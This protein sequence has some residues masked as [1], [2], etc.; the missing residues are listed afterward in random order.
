MACHIA[1]HSFR[2]ALYRRTWFL[3][4]A[5]CAVFPAAATA[6]EPVSRR[7]VEVLRQPLPPEDLSLET[8]DDV[9]RIVGPT[10]VYTVDRATGAIRSFSARRGDAVVVESTAPVELSLDGRKL[11]AAGVAEINVMHRTPAKIELRAAGV[12]MDPEGKSPP[13]DFLLE[14]TFY[15]D[16][17]VKTR[18]TLV[19]RAETAVT[20]DLVCRVPLE[21]R[22]THAFNKLR[23]DDGM[24]VRAAA[25]PGAG[26]SMS[27]TGAT[28]CLQ[29]FSSEAAVA[30]FTDRGGLN[31]SSPE[32]ETASIA[33]REAADGAVSAVLSQHIVRI[34]DGADPMTL[35]ADRVFVFRTGLAVAPNRL[36]HPRR[37]DVRIFFWAGDAKHPYPTD[38]EIYDVAGLGFNVFQMHRVGSPGLPREPEGELDR[39]IKTVHEANMLFQW[40]ENVDLMYAHDPAVLKMVADGKWNLWQ[41]FNY[42]GRYTASMDPYCDMKATC[43]ASPNGLAEYRV[44]TY[45]RMFARYP[46]D[47]MYVDDN[48]PYANCG[49]W[50]EHGHPQPV[51][52][53]L[54]EL[55]EVNW[56]RRRVFLEHCPHALL[57]D[58]CS[59]CTLLPTIGAFDSHLYGEGYN[60]STP[61]AYWDHFGALKSLYG[62]GHICPGD[63]ESVRCPTESAYAFDLLCGGGQYTYLDWRLYPQKFPHAA[64]VTPDERPLVEAYNLAQY[65]FGMYESTPFYF[66]TSKNHFTTTAPS[67][68]AT[69]YRNDTWGDWLLALA[70]MAQEDRTTTLTLHDAAAIGL[71]VGAEWLLWDVGQRT[72]RRLA[73]GQL[74]SA[75]S[76]ISLGPQSVKLLF[77]RR[78]PASGAFALWGGKRLREHWDAS[79]GRLRLELEGPPTRTD[80]VVIAPGEEPLCEVRVNGKPAEFFFDAEKRLVHGWVT[81]GSEPVVVEADTTGAGLPVAPLSN[82]RLARE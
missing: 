58:H 56:A 62:Q 72:V 17:V 64:G 40:T 24:G 35:Q 43:L 50:K 23:S 42:G 52:D 27:W 26:K 46:V 65:Y 31:V 10:F 68:Y 6:N 7:P 78:V 60:M 63:S 30:V 14:H 19:P 39:V 4:P 45:R 79:A 38:E 37:R 13:V 21:G 16:G 33:V 41:G 75:L 3:L 22:F 15:N 18:W 36:P 67:T 80:I 34:A 49:L 29:A 53:C 69:L 55:H 2:A 12:L 82:G 61:E 1:F 44:E 59:W 9:L 77:L 81:F 73:P 8:T 71:D 25:L 74:S 76:D 11:S 20:R 47:S 48:L 51:Y 28:S 66:A 32:L 5:L 54:M 70:N 57:F